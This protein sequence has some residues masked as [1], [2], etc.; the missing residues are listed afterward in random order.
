MAVGL[1]GDAQLFQPTGG[2]WAGEGGVDEDDTGI[3]APGAAEAHGFAGEFVTGDAAVEVTGD[4]AVED[5]VA[6][7]LGGGGAG[8]SGEVAGA[9][10]MEFGAVEDG[11]G[12]AEDEV[13]AALDVGVDV[14][15]AAVVGEEGVLVAEEAAVL[16]DGTVGADGGGDGLAGI[17]CCVLKGEVVG[18][19]AVAV[20]LGG[21]GEEGSA[22]G[23]GVQGVGDD[24]LLRGLAHAEEGD[25]GVVLGDDD[26]LVIGAGGDLDE[27]AAGRAVGT[28]ARERVMVKGH[29]DGGEFGDGFDAGFE[30]GVDAYV[31]VL[32][33]GCGG[34]EEEGGEVP[35]HES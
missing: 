30:D 2:T 22:G 35:M 32:R 27:D 8:V 24:D 15:L 12:V 10:G 9:V 7:G 6:G 20:D 29:L 18:L 1:A 26:A 33:E 5:D 14:V 4:A 13:D 25:V 3:G 31:D 16:E 21:L 23:P 17:V 28:F 19:E 34:E 11:G